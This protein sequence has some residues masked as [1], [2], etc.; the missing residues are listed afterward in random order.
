MNNQLREVYNTV[1]G[2]HD[3]PQ[4]AVVEKFAIAKYES[5][6]TLGIPRL[7]P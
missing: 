2:A 5:V 3:R 6:A 7:F 4:R 1:V